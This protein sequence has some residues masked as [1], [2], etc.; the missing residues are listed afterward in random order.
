M[1]LRALILLLF[2]ILWEDQQ[3]LASLFGSFQSQRQALADKGFTF[4][5]NDIEDYVSG[6]EDAVPVKGQKS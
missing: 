2:F 3:A 6:K 1:F 4:S 5:L